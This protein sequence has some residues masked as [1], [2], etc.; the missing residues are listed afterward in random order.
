MSSA[1]YPVDT[2]HQTRSLP[3]EICLE[4]N[5][6]KWQ[7]FFL[8]LEEMLNATTSTSLSCMIPA[9]C[10]IPICKDFSHLLERPQHGE[11]KLMGRRVLWRP[12][13]GTLEKAEQKSTCV[14][15]DKENSFPQHR[16]Q[17]VALQ[18]TAAHASTT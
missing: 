13:C 4:I 17:I 3:Q 14:H 18:V 2:V 12:F 7:I 16:T 8:H 6:V 9:H 11:R 15:R 5:G 10:H 1:R